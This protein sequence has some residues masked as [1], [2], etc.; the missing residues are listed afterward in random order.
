MESVSKGE[1]VKASERKQMEP[2]TATVV[3]VAVWTPFYLK[4][5][6]WVAD[7]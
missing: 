3:L 2:I 4:V 6:R 7:L 1:M 5:C